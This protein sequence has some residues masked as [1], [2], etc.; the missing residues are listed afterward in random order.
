[1]QFG[2]LLEREIAVFKNE[3]LFSSKS[4]SF[5]NVDPGVAFD[6]VKNIVQ[7]PSA[8]HKCFELL[9]DRNLRVHAVDTQ[10]VLFRK[11]CTCFYAYL[12]GTQIVSDV[13]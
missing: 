5:Y 7:L 12:V 13:E 2:K 6:E 10:E 8:D 1:L 4:V 9:V 3:V 11:K